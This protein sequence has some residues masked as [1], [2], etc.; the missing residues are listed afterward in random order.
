MTPHE[1]GPRHATPPA[2]PADDVALGPLTDALRRESPLPL[3]LRARVEARVLSTIRK[4]A[5]SG[6]AHLITGCGLFLLLGARPEVVVV[7]P[8]AVLLFAAVVA[9]ARFVGVLDGEDEPGQ[10]DAGQKA[11]R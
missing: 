7:G 3:G 10:G 4:P 6:L 8:L 2:D 9:Y 11:A 1:S 5:S